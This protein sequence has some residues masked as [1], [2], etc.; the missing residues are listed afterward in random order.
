M[1]VNC[2]KGKVSMKIRMNAFPCGDYKPCDYANPLGILDFTQNARFEVPEKVPC[3]KTCD[4]Y[5]VD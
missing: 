5:E 4:C 1:Y 3:N 2:H